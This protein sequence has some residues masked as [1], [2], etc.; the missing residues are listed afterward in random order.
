MSRY[1]L[2]QSDTAGHHLKWKILNQISTVLVGVNKISW[3][4]THSSDALCDGGEL[5]DMEHLLSVWVH[6]PLVTYD[7]QKN[8]ADIARSWAK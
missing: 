1:L 3:E 8:A 2:Y 6:A 4:Q 7:F 5:Q